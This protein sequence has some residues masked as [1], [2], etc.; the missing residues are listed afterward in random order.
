MKRV[1]VINP[2]RFY[3]FLALLMLVSIVL[4]FIV[5]SFISNKP[6]LGASE[7][8]THSIIVHSGDTIW[9]IA[10]PIALLQKKDTR[11]VVREIYRLNNLEQ[12]TIHPGQSLLVPNI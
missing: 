2:K 10:E 11:N 8:E 9:S 5:M 12:M 1:R 4:S 6:A 7:I 3:T